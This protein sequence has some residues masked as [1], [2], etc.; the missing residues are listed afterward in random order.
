MT[1]LAEC[2]SRIIQVSRSARAIRS[3]WIAGSAATLAER[4]T[5]LIDT[6]G[7]DGLMLAVPNF[8]A[9]L[10]FV[11]R[12]VLPQL[13]EAVQSPGS[14]VRLLFPQRRTS[15]V[16]RQDSHVAPRPGGQRQ[17]ADRAGRFRCRTLDSRLWTGDY[18]GVGV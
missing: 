7:F 13:R 5:A 3:A 12:R 4:L 14:K 9:D 6:A 18:S 17:P 15:A 1:A 16:R 2:T 10:A 8:I 11:G